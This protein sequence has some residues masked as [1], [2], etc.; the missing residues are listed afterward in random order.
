LKHTFFGRVFF[1]GILSNKI[2]PYHIDLFESITL[3]VEVSTVSS[4]TDVT[5]T[6]STTENPGQTLATVFYNPGTGRVMLTN[7]GYTKIELNDNHP[8][9]D[10]LQKSA[11]S[12]NDLKNKIAAYIEQ[13]TVTTQIARKVLPLIPRGGKRRKTRRRRNKRK[14]SRR[15]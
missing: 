2:Y 5:L 11:G 4:S 9:Y 12:P 1:Y 14:Y 3:T 6:V 7:E 10:K 15:R 13:H 8:E